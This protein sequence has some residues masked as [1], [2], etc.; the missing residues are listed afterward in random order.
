MEQTKSDMDGEASTRTG[1]SERVASVER[2]KIRVLYDMAEQHPNDDLVR[3][4]IGEPDF[5]TPA[6]VVEAAADAAAA[7]DTHY[8]SNAGRLELREAIADRVAAEDGVSFDPESEIAI[9]TGGME[10]LHLALLCIADAGDEVV[11]PTPAWPNYVTQARLANATP[12][13]VPL[14]SKDGFTLDADRVIDAITDDTAAVM[15]TSPSNPTGRVY[16]VDVMEEITAAAARHDAHVVADEVYKGLTYD[17]SPQ[18]LAAVTDHPKHVLTVNSFSK[19]YAM[20]GWRVGWLAGPEEVIDRVVAVHE[21]TTACASSVAQ[22]AAREALTGPQ[23]P[24]EDMYRAFEERRDYVLK[25]LQ[26][27]PGISCPRPEGAFYAFPDVSALDG[28]SFEIA[29]RLLDEYGVVAAPGSGFSDAGE[30]H[31][32]FSFA[33]SL[34]RLEVGM[35][36]F[37][38]MVRDER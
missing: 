7:G 27:I 18:S 24:F 38:E 19:R 20:T 9:T 25:R 1:V 21:S 37:E 22:R 30:G 6:H 12:V 32:R 29:E 2:S 3:L 23:K 14:S 31:L 36:R 35:D 28:T 26:D 33:N 16:D 10:A 34:E 8:T 17:E 4:E 13:E 5:D 15:L 11:V